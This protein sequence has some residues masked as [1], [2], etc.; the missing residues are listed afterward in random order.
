MITNNNTVSQR[1]EFDCSYLVKSI[2]S[3]QYS[4]QGCRYLVEATVRNK[5][6]TESGVVIEFRKLRSYLSACVPDHTFLYH[7]SSSVASQ[8]AS[9]LSQIG[10]LVKSYAVP[11]CAENIC[12]N[13]AF[14]L[15]ALLDEYSP[16]VIVVEVKLRE[17]SDSVAT[18]KA[19]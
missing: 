6:A 11:I 15:Q 14:Q 2:D 16:G 7:H 12:E 17:N 1:I 4:L 8:V 18:Y 10:V 3:A 19:G 13:I 5:Y 9:T